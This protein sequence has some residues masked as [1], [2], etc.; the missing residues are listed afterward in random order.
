MKEHLTKRGSST[1][2]IGSPPRTLKAGTATVCTR[3]RGTFNQSIGMVD[4]GSCMPHQIIVGLNNLD[5]MTCLGQPFNKILLKAGLQFE[6]RGII[7]PCSP[8]KPA[9][10]RDRRLQVA[11]KKGVATENGGLGLGLT[12][13]AHGPVCQHPAIPEGGQRR[14]QGVKWKAAR[15]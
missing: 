15:A 10:S 7:T 6:I 1:L 8:Q 3:V 2:F 13:A 5:I 4:H 14:I 11:V 12:L 9:R